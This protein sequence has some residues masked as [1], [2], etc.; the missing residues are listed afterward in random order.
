MSDGE[1]KE[2]F[3]DFMRDIKHRFFFSLFRLAYLIR[4]DKI[5][6][7]ER[8]GRSAAGRFTSFCLT[9]RLVPDQKTRLQVQ[10]PACGGPSHIPASSAAR[11]R[12]ARLSVGTGLPLPVSAH[13]GRDQVF[14]A[15]AVLFSKKTTR[16]GSRRRHRASG[17]WS[18]RGSCR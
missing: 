12:P 4:V 3:N 14:L 6:Q 5:Q 15:T 8:R 11:W 9:T 2:F 7:R 13:C 17:R 1:C 10:P 18:S 16:A